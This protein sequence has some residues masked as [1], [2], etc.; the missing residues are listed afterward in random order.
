VETVAGVLDEK[1]NRPGP[2]TEQWETMPC[3]ALCQGSAFGV[4]RRGSVSKGSVAREDGQ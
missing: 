1:D 3:Q 2:T 4:V